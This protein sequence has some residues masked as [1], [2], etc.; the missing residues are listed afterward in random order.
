MNFEIKVNDEIVMK[1]LDNSHAEVQFD[2]VQKNR[3][4]LREFLPW[5]DKTHTVDDALANIQKSREGFELKESLELGIFYKDQ[6]VGRCGFISKMKTNSAEIGYW[7]DQDYNGKGIMAQCVKKLAEY[8]LGELG[9]HRIV[10]RM[11]KTNLPSR[12]IPK[13]IGFTYEGTERE[14]ELN[15]DGAWRDAEVWSFIQ[16]DNF[17][18]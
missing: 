5:V 8:G 2:I 17:L 3:E 15:S 13:K 18:I 11:D 1:L 7:L 14:S 12:A 6:F 4:F 9:K 16:G 10:I